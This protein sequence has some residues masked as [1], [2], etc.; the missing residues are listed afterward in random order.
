MEGGLS[1]HE[2]LELTGWVII[3]DVLFILSLL[4]SSLGISLS[5]SLIHLCLHLGGLNFGI[6]NRR[7]IIILNLYERLLENFWVR[8]SNWHDWLGSWKD[9]S[10]PGIASH[11]IELNGFE[12]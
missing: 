8:A 7:K 10:W 6:F 12:H 4:L 5:D 2:T 1:I 3:L 11:G 9:R